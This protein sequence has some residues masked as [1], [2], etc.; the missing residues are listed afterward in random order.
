MNLPTDDTYPN[1]ASQEDLEKQQDL[2]ERIV[3]EI[4]QM[5]DEAKRSLAKSFSSEVSQI[6]EK[7]I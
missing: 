2:N 3:G 5:S 7:S 4:N 6:C 1:E